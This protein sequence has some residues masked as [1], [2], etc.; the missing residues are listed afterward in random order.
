[1]WYRLEK[2]SSYVLG[3]YVK[4]TE[5][6]R[7]DREDVLC[8]EAVREICTVSCTDYFT[9]ISVC[10]GSGFYISFHIPS[11]QNVVQWLYGRF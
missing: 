10:I 1:M 2:T 3:K 5:R 9:S 6:R 7:E 11:Y 4:H 8:E